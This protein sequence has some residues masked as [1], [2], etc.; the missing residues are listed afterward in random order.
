MICTCGEAHPHVAMRRKTSDAHSVVIWSD[1]A[2]TQELGYRFPGVPIVRPKAEADVDRER[3]ASFMFA[4]W[5]SVYDL[6]ELPGL[7]RAFREAA[8]RGG[9]ERMARDLYRQAT[10][11]RV[12]VVWTVTD[13]DARGRPTERQ[14]R[15][16]RLR[17]PGMA[18][19]DSMSSPK[20]Y[21][22]VCVI[23]GTDTIQPYSGL[24]FGT[25]AEVEAFLHTVPRP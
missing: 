17:W 15:L 14:T 21:S 8:R 11:P 6:E 4:Q 19:V 22:V 7:Y 23:P 2:V 18:V 10:R 24:D 9:D 5:V 13:A 12:P 20:R 25:W 16:P 3:R 1:G